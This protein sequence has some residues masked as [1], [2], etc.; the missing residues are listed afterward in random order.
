MS[1][2]ATVLITGA[3]GGLGK[4]TATA[5]LAAGANVVI[6][7][8]NQGRLDSTS[9]EWTEAGYD[10]KF[11]A[12]TTNVT[13]PAS[14]QEYVA[15]AVA[16]FGRVDVV[17][18]NAGIMDDFSGAAECTQE[19][20]HR[21][22]SV[23]VNGPYYLIQASI[24]QMEKQT[25]GAPGG[26]FI[27]ICSTSAVYGSTCGAAYT[28]SKHGLLGLHKNTAFTYRDKG[29]YSVA[30]IMGGMDTNVS[31]GM[32]RGELDIE[33]YKRVK[34]SRPFDVEKDLVPLDTVAKTI[35]F[36]SDRS[37]AESATGGVIDLKKN[38][39]AN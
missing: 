27:N 13:D 10:G 19:M 32:K 39:P 5:F 16:K 36:F 18:N 7:D 23:N 2:P 24:K 9:K 25:D 35:M 37:I 30:L 29:I 15:A 11:L 22:M 33:G 12:T 3:G 21:V 20:W 31:D 17:V 14:V 26:V 4:A 28:A 6:C 1:T 34:A 38:N 8:V